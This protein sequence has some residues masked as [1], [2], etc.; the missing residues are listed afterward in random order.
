MKKIRKKAP[1]KKADLFGEIITGLFTVV[2]TPLY[3]VYRIFFA[4]PRT[5]SPFLGLVR[6]A[7]YFAIICWTT[8]EQGIAIEREAAIYLSAF[9]NISLAKLIV[10]SFGL[11]CVILGFISIL[12]FG[13]FHSEMEYTGDPRD[14]DGGAGHPYPNIHRAM[15]DFDGRLGFGTI[16]GFATLAKKIMK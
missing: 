13:G 6:L 8:S 12:I 16:H 2:L 1:V 11:V 7:T 4:L 10:S 15:K 14:L 5:C 3:F 9:M